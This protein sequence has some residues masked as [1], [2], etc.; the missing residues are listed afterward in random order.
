MS[1]RVE[2]ARLLAIESAGGVAP[3]WTLQEY[4]QELQNPQ[5]RLFAPENVAGGVDAF[6][7]YRELDDEAWILQL[8]VERKGQGLG[9]KLLKN[10]LDFLRNRNITSVGLEVADTN[11]AALALYKGCGF[12]KI[13]ERKAYYRNGA[14]AWVMKCQL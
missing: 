8:A 9:K 5:A 7:A 13:G 2:A 1:G 11:T 10:F 14:A 3:L 6:V 4:E 12:E